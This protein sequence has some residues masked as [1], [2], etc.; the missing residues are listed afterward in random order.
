MDRAERDTVFS[1]RFALHEA[2]LK[3]LYSSLYHEDEQAYRYFV[4]M[5]G[6]MYAQRGSALRAIDEARERDPGWYKGHALVGM[7]MYVKAFAGTLRGVREK[8]DY[9]EDCGVN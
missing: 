3:Q 7:L 1:R 6:R 4:E 2:E 8:L 9:I 5:L